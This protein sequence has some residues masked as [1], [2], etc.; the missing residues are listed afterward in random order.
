MNPPE[1]IKDTPE[2]LMP[3]RAIRGATVAAANSE[4]AILAA[5]RQLLEQ[6]AAANA[7]DPL[8]LISIFFTMTSDLN[9]AFPTR[10]ARELGWSHVPLLDAQQPAVKGDLERC[11]RVM[12]HCQTERS[13]TEIKH[14]YLGEAKRLRPDLA[15][16]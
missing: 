7:L 2:K 4:T 9:A 6:L 1:T 15:D 10:A 5:A 3:T 12:I 13:V 16:K 11:L 14:V 8:H